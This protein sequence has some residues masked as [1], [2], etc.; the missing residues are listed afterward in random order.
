MEQ[1]NNIPCVDGLRTQIVVRGGVLIAEKTTHNDTGK[2]MKTCYKHYTKQSGQHDIVGHNLF[3]EEKPMFNSGLL[4][5]L[6]N[7]EF[8]KP[9]LS[10]V[11][12][13]SIIGTIT[14]IELKSH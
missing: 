1:L 7:D 12:T 2:K 8:H 13:H 3:S 10:I 14:I 4:K 11:C 6:D 9:S 5:A